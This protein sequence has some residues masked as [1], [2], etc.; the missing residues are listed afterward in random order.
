MGQ[1]TDVPHIIGCLLQSDELVRANDRH[2]VVLF[3]RLRSVSN[4]FC[5]GPQPMSRS[6]FLWVSVGGLRSA[7]M[8]RH[9]V[10]I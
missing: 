10:S 4:I 1:D 7:T 3:T 5:A 8:V 2:G 9:D 6:V